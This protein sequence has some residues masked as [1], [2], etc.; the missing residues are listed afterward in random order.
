MYRFGA[1]QW[2]HRTM[3][4]LINSLPKYRKHK[5]SGQAVVTLAGVDYYLGPHGTKA[6]KRQYDRLVAEWLQH[7]RR[8][9]PTGESITIVELAARYLRFAKAYYQK[10]GRCTKVAPAVKACIKYLKDWYG[11]EP[12]ADFGPLALKAVRQ[13]MVE[14]GL[15]RRYV[16]D[17]AARIKRMF[18]WAVG[19]QL[20][21]PATWQALAAVPGL[22]RGKTEARDNPPIMPVDDATV[23]A[24]LPHLPE[25]V[26]D[27]LRLQRLTGMR[28]AEV[29][30]VRPCD[31]D[32]SG[33]VWLYR[34]AS[35]KTEHHG[36]ER[37]VFLGAEAQCVLL[38]YLA[39]DPEA[40]CFRPCDSEA[41]RRAEVH[42]TRQTPLSCGNRPGSNRRR[43][44]QHK[45]GDRYEVDAY[46]RAITR[47][48]DKAFPH[49]TLARV[50]AADLTA[51]Q[52]AELRQ[53]Q[54]NHRWAPNRLRHSYATRVRRECGLE[55]AQ[56][57]L[58]HSGADVTQIYAERDLAKGLEVARR[59]G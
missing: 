1:Q 51:A 42:A 37:I 48:C 24:T 59:I 14:D 23:D 25:V 56:V 38:R 33:D 22:V 13:R 16:N 57:V 40:Y 5:A 12:A 41:K 46:R 7:D 17:H 35:H 39:R 54:R 53:W 32:R 50:P 58:G 29:C 52:V 36:R 47:A 31:V 34:P 45:P 8:L 27:M 3:P 2:E 49:P 11:S 20:I 15:S 21:P 19:E 28:P 4:R 9:Q 43:K 44:P 26:A 30:I 10:D 6:A 18:K 55:A